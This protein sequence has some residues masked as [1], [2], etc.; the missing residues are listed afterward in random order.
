MSS[1]SMA[2]AGSWQRPHRGGSGRILERGGDA[3]WW[4]WDQVSNE[5]KPTGFTTR[6]TTAAMAWCHERD[7][8]SRAV[9]LRNYGTRDNEKLTQPRMNNKNNVRVPEEVGPRRQSPSPRLVHQKRTSH[10]CLV[11]A[12]LLSLRLCSRRSMYQIDI[13]LPD[14]LLRRP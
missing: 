4:V 1:L 11:V 6:S 12:R 8:S 3:I 5:I 7:L 14:D 10:V 13:D 2:M 9:R